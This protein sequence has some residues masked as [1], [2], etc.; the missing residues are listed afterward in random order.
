MLQALLYI[1]IVMFGTT[2]YVVGVKQMLSGDYKPSV[3]SRVIW[4]MLTINSFAGV[5]LSQGS[6]ASILLA[7]ILLVGNIAICSVSFWKGVRT[8]GKI[9]VI[10]T[11]LLCMSGLVWL[12][13]HAPL[14]NLGISL[15]AYTI[16]AIPTYIKVWHDPASESTA[17]WAPFV[18]ASTLSVVVS[19]GQP[20][21]AVVLPIYFALFDF[22]M[23]IL[24]MRSRK[25]T[26]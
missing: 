10:C 14:V 13:F 11:A 19:L 18:F 21:G 4:L 2:S 9:E 25:F 23:T 3:F 22:S 16:G 17:F 24:S 5:I 1:L 26:K 20:L 7:F 15:L 12:F 6:K 8:F